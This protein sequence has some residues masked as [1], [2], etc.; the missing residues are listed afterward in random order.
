VFRGTALEPEKQATGKRTLQIARV[1][2]KGDSGL[3]WV[4]R[5]AGCYNEAPDFI[6]AYE[7]I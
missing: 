5:I 2:S 1:A 4:P 3:A 7:I 6:K